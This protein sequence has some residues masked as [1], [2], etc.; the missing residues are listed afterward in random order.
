MHRNSKE[1]IGVRITRRFLT[2]LI[3]LTMLVC[4][5]PQFASAAAPPASLDAPPHFGVTYNGG[6]S[7]KLYINAPV[8]IRDYIAREVQDNPEKVNL[9]L[10]YQVD[11][12]INNGSWHY[13]SEWDSPKT[14]PDNYK[15]KYQLTCRNGEYYAG[16]DYAYLSH[17]TSDEEVVKALKDSGWD[18]FKSNSIT[19]RARFAHSFDNGDTYV[20]SPWSKE[21]VLSAGVKL[22][23]EKM[24]NHAP[25]LNGAEIEMHGNIP[26][27][28]VKLNKAPLDIG[29]LNVASGGNVGAEI[30]L[31][32]QGDKEFKNIH[33]WWV[34]NESIEFETVNYFD[35]YKDRYEEAAFEIKVRY[36]LDLRNYKQSE[37]YG[38]SS[39]VNIYSP[40]S[41][42][43]SQNTPAWSNAS[44][45]ATGELKKADDAGLIPEILKGADLTKPITREEFCEL[46]LLLYEKTTG[47]SPAP[48]SS[49]PFT[50][51]NNP[52]ILKAFA[53][54]I[55]QGTSATTFS[56]QVFINR[57][58]C[59]TMLYRT[60][61]AIH[62]EGD[63]S[64][65]GI[66]DFPDQKDI[67]S[68]A[69]EGT[70]FMSKLGIIK[71]DNNG[72]FMPKAITSAQIAAGYG[73][74][75]R[76]A[77]LLMGVRTYDKMDEIKASS[78]DTMSE[79]TSSSG[80]TTSGNT[81]SSIAGTWVMGTLTD[82]SFNAGTGKYEG[83]MSGLG[84]MYTFNPDGT[85]TALAI[86]SEAIWISGRYSI[87]DGVLTLTNRTSENS[88]DD[89]KTW[90][91]KETIPDTTA[92]FEAGTD[93]SGKYLLL[94]EEGATPPLVD[95]KNALKYS[96]KEPSQGQEGATGQSQISIPSII[97]IWQNGGMI[98]HTFDVTIGTF[99]YNSGVGQRYVFKEDGTFT[100]SIVSTY[101]NMIAI[102]GTYTVKDDKITFSNQ[103]GKVSDDYGKTWKAGNAP[104]DISH[105]YYFDTDDS[106]TSLIIGLED[107]VPP[108][109]T[110]TN[111]VRYSLMDE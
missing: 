51:T 79:S 81:S 21:F 55:T 62:P 57:E 85:Y 54:G 32:K 37:H 106:G 26:F 49:N 82:G 28:A 98:G 6:E 83:G 61:K 107:A 8:S 86:W 3:A 84:M 93:E 23:T 11:I 2:I 4:L 34:S 24:I 44:S 92:Y 78:G 56:P 42:V 50:D 20:L 80:D 97:G 65:V 108:L 69:V 31:R 96:L 15:S 74:A 60:I 58:Q 66:K 73:M 100:S 46:A 41:N 76:E 105:Y 91:A 109:D 99:R 64:I 16:S 48:A 7:F 104:P 14:V 43:I 75:T 19:F 17:F 67:S 22:D 1:L 102:T 10:K 27:L 5:V 90:G 12:K 33:N 18:Y 103:S 110:E 68:F 52:Q 72:N 36:F 87:K 45:W 35:D 89:G 71:G 29:D 70:K 30:W 111:A 63:Y 94:G 9:T 95:K 59:A 47:K 25:T 53:L 101:G 88:D 40:F 39:S 38:A 77:A 13:T